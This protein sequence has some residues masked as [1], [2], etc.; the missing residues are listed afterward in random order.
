MCEKWA[1]CWTGGGLVWG[2][3][4]GWDDKE[5]AEKRAAML[6]SL[7]PDADY[8]VEPLDPCHCEEEA[9]TTPPPP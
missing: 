1:I 7:V 6:K 5:E 2:R 8:W 9:G 4:Q 3:S